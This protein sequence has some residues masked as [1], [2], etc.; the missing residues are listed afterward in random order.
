MTRPLTMA[1][2][3]QVDGQTKVLNE[4][5]KI[6]LHA[7]IRPSR[8]DWTSYLDALEPSYNTSPLQPQDLHPHVC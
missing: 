6:S 5:L 1:C 7:Y 2:H 3:P 4:S 8:N